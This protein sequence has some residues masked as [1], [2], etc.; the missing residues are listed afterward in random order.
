MGKDAVE[1]KI[2]LLEQDVPLEQDVV[3]EQDVALE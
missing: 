2:T 3:I 1:I